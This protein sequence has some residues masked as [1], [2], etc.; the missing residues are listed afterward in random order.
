VRSSWLR[1]LLCTCACFGLAPL[2]SADSLGSGHALSLC[3]LALQNAVSVHN[4][5][6][7]IVA[8]FT[9]NDGFTLDDAASAC[10][11]SGFDWVQIITSLPDPVPVERVDGTPI[12]AG[13]TPFNDP[14]PGGGYTYCLAIGFTCDGY[15]FY[16]ASGSLNSQCDEK[17]GSGA[18]ILTA[19]SDSGHTLNFFDSPSDFCIDDLIG[20]SVTYSASACD[21]TSAPYGSYMGFHT[22]LAGIID[23]NPSVLFSG[24]DDAWT[25]TDDFNGTVGGVSTTISEL[26]VDLGSGDGGI[27]I[28]SGAI[29]TP[30]PTAP[31]L[32]LVALGTFALF[33][34]VTSKAGSQ[35]TRAE[36]R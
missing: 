31:N 3:D 23:G 12:T 16:Y 34:F 33:K 22:A 30:E 27:T 8:N 29:T 2:A 26:P 6:T 24:L 14:P 36:R 10:G 17:D 13:S 19:I 15:P 35:K 5:G 32:G 18:C 20:H 4:D 7:S 9:P 28:T 11:F 25:W 1:L 21:N